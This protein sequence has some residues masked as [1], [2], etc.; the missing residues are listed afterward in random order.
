MP[1]VPIFSIPLADKNVIIEYTITPKN[2]Y[3][4][5]SYDNFKITNKLDLSKDPNY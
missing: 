3:Y 4:G 2:S 1:K 5:R